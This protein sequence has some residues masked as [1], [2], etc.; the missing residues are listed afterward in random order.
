MGLFVDEISK[1][2]S[3]SGWDKDKKLTEMLGR[4]APKLSEIAALAVRLNKWTSAGVFGEAECVIAEPG[5]IYDSNRMANDDDSRRT[6]KRRSVRNVPP[7]EQVICT[8]GLGLQ[9]VRDIDE[10]EDHIL[11]KPK[12]V[13]YSALF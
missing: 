9:L 4:L 5:I 8:V 6:D 2:F 7:S 12:V 10:E 3:L 1:I 11:L 13:L